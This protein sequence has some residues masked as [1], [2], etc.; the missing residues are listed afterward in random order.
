MPRPENL[1]LP[2]LTRSLSTGLVAYALRGFSFTENL[3]LRKSG[4]P[5]STLGPE[6][7]HCRQGIERAICAYFEGEPRQTDDFLQLGQTRSPGQE[8]TNGSRH[9]RQQRDLAS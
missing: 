6:T 5:Q 4:V 8:L 1:A 7:C 3:T 2:I 9:M